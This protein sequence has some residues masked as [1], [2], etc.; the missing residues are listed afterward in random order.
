MRPGGRTPSN[1]D[2]FATEPP[3][4]RGWMQEPPH[5]MALNYGETMAGDPEPGEHEDMCSRAAP[6][7]GQICPQLRA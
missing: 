3:D 7:L 4:D 1:V 5:V 6:T 2:P